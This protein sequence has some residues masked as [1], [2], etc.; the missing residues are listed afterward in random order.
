LNFGRH[1]SFNQA[2][3]L[4]QTLRSVRIIRTLSTSSS[5]AVRTEPFR[6]A[7]SI[8]RLRNEPHQFVIAL[9]E[10]RLSVG[11]IANAINTASLFCKIVQP[12]SQVAL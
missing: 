9:I 7:N 4:E 2:R 6:I 11:T 10:L 12:E 5:L 1:P 8:I 3:Y